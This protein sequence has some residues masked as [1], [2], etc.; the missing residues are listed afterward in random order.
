M[1][2]GA[3]KKIIKGYSHL[4]RAFNILENGYNYRPCT[5]AK[6]NSQITMEWLFGKAGAIF[7]KVI[8]NSLLESDLT[9][10]SDRFGRLNKI[11]KQMED[12]DPELKD[13]VFN[14]LIETTSH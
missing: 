12:A 3:I 5:W 10:L 14:N 2:F 4:E 6:N 11:I 13:W 1:E 8:S 7:E 9:K